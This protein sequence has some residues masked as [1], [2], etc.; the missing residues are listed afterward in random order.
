MDAEACKST[1][2]GRLAFA[3]ALLICCVGC[4]RATKC[5][6]RAVL[7]DVPPRI[8]LS[9]VVRLEHALNPGAFLSL[10]S[11][12]PPQLRFWTFVLLNAVF[13]VLGGCVLVAK[14]DMHSA[15][16]V[17]VALLLAGGLGNLL[18]RVFQDGLVTDFISLGVGPVRTG[19]FNVADLGLTL[20]AI[21]L[22]CAGSKAQSLRHEPCRETNA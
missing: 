22:V 6:A 3:L 15:K 4:D 5:V 7:R 2:A 13:L 1:K 8:Y 14:W 16:F 17:A 18:D 10:G 19:V 20:G 21:L 11:T 12:L 9:G